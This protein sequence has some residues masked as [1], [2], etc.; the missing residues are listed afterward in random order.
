MPIDK[1]LMNKNVENVEALVP[2]IPMPYVRWDD[3]YIS[4]ACLKAPFLYV[5]NALSPRYYIDLGELLNMHSYLIVSHNEGVDIIELAAEDLLM[6]IMIFVII[7]KHS[8]LQ[9]R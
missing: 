5:M 2:E 9:I 3:K 4:D 1:S 7:G 6:S 8:H